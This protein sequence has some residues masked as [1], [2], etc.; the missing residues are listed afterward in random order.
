MARVLVADNCPDTLHSWA[1]LLR[2]WGHEV[3]TA[4]DGPT[5]LVAA[6]TGRPDVVLMDVALRDLDGLAVA[7][8]LRE[9]L[10]P[11]RPL[12]VAATGFEGD[13]YRR[14]AFAAGFDFFL[15]KPAE[16]DLL[17]AILA[18]APAEPLPGWAQP[19]PTDLVSCTDA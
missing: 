5:A 7:R 1:L 14:A 13:R 6:L 10:G 8:R 9:Q 3:E 19:C 4:G 12:L 17:R 16:A 2:L 11:S 15:V 18:A